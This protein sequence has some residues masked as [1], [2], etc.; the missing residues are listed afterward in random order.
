M[1]NMNFDKIFVLGGGAI[2]SVYG[3]FLSKR[4]DVALIGNKAHVKAV[5]SKGLAVSGDINE[6]FYLRADTEIH[7]IPEKTLILLTT[8]AYDL[9]KTVEKTNKLL[10]ED[11]I[12]LI[13]Q[14][15]LG[16]EEIVK[17]AVGDEARI[18]RG[19]TTM[20]A[21]FFQPGKIRFWNGETTIEQ[22]EVAKKIAK[23]FN[24]CMLKTMLSDDIKKE[25]WNK[26]IV[27]CVTNP[28]SAVFHVK[29]YEIV[30]DSLT[31]V[32][33][34][35]VK[36]CVEVGEAEGITF[37]EHLEEKIDEKICTYTNFSSMYQ[38]IM[39]GKR[40]EI[41]FLNGKV[42]QL[43]RKHHITTPVNETLVCLT[44]FME[45]KNGIPRKD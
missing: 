31:T 15:G 13:L 2:G 32:R 5:N 36:E 23:I 16:N 45:E 3:A 10:K 38:D 4:S 24:E 35:I 8:K 29:N 33:H 41:D 1:R 37:P 39:K 14:N 42:V 27:N 40:T 28:L 11:T 30:A 43:G 6:T 22:N 17:R 12:I 21:E 9:A 18:L 19:I 34:K 20:A 7:E 25:L 44:K 26:L